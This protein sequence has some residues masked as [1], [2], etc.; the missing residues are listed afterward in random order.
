[1]E[2]L[3]GAP[4][5]ASTDRVGGDGGDV[6]SRPESLLSTILSPSMAN[7]FALG[8]EPNGSR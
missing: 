8:L 2:G 3:G 4:G 5:L 1:V 6:R 7:K